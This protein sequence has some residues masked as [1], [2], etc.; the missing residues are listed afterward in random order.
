MNPILAKAMRET[1]ST[2]KNSPRIDGNSV[3]DNAYKK[4]IRT[5]LDEYFENKP[6]DGHY[7]CIGCA[8]CLSP[9][10]GTMQY[11]YPKTLHSVNKEMF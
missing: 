1:C 7:K 9:H 5:N 6:M 2:M 3:H 4:Y 8:K 11:K 10:K